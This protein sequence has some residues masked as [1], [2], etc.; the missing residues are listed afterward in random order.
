MMNSFIHI[1]FGA[2]PAGFQKPGR[3]VSRNRFFVHLRPIGS[4][5][6]NRSFLWV[7]LVMT[8]SS[9]R[10]FNKYHAPEYDTQGLFRNENPTDTTTIADI[11]WRTYFA[12]AALAALID[13]GLK[14]NYDLRIAVTRIRQAEAN[15]GLARAAFFPSVTLAGQAAEARTS[16]GNNGTKV[17]GYPRDQFT[18]SAVVSWE[19]DLWG[20]FFSQKRA[21]YA[22]F[23]NTH[24]YRNLVQTS[25]IANIAN[26][27]Y[28]LLAMDEQLRITEET[29]KL[30]EESAATMQAL[31]DAGMLN[32][33]AVEQSRALLYGTQTTI[34][35]IENQI[36]QLENSLCLMIVR[37]PDSVVRTTLAMQSLPEELQHGVPAQMLARRPDVQQ[38]ELNFRSAFE[39]TNAARAAFYPNI[40]LGSSSA[41]S[42]IGYTSATI[43]DFFKPENIL[44]NIVVGMTQPIFA[45][46]Q[47][48]SSLKVAK[49]QQEEALL[50]F[51][52]S[53]LSASKEV[54]DILYTYRSSLRK[55]D[56]RSK[57]V[58]SLK[59]AVEYTKEL[60]IAGEANYTEVLTAEQNLLQAQLGQVNDMLEQLQA[61]VNLYRALGGGTE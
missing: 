30:L 49:A 45:R 50:T 28:T 51:E 37:K 32:A 31:K 34:P 58:E 5:R 33:A 24:A 36:R 16:T 7:L 54:S 25:L 53:V 18:L 27:Y 59:T 21:Q 4:L 60:L 19:I 14:N 10:I 1:I 39:L 29:V 17:L 56:T 20:Q 22:R 48:T 55:N 15:L 6:P 52:Q 61:T 47:L 23:L 42:M 38:A 57:Q 8:L 41:A 13:S 12:D 44:A 3:F 26:T 11:P 9:C 35:D 2:K 43:T 46:G 40:T